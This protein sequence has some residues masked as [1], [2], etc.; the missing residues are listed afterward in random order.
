LNSPELP[1]LAAPVVTR[2]APETPKAPEAGVR[3]SKVPDVV[4]ALTPVVTNT[5]PPVVA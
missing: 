1:A 5:W 3:R 2:T 4:C